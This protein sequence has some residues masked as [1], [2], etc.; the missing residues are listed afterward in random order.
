ME[1]NFRLAL[2]WTKVLVATAALLFGVHTHAVVITYDSV[3]DSDNV[4]TSAVAGATVVDFNDNTCGAYAACSGD[5]TIVSGSSRG[6]YAAPFVTA[7]NSPDTTNYL[8][9]PNPIRNGSALF[10]LGTT[11]NYFGLLWGSIDRY[12]SIAFLSGASVVASF[13]GQ[14][15]TRP[16]AANGNQTAPSTNT[17]VNFFDLPSFDAVRLISTNFAFESDNHAFATVPE[18]GTLS[19]L[20][21]GLLGL[22]LIRRRVQ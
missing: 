4:S 5:F 17:Y 20:A 19:L 1:M 13:T 15:I 12:N 14:S 6:L 8:S 10:E 18:P 3:L 22:V 16:S 11:A 2:L 9:V 21:F 7:A